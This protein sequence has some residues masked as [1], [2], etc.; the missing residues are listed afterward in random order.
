M[1]TLVKAFLVIAIIVGAIII[2]TTAFSLFAAN[3][4]MTGI[5]DMAS[6]RAGPA[7][8]AGSY[9]EALRNLTTMSCDEALKAVN[10]YPGLANT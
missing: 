8:E 3:Q 7:P 9:E 4:V 1:R 2:G 6:E 5:K 10:K